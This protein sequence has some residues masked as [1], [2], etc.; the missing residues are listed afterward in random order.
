MAGSAKT[1]RLT[2]LSG[3][4]LLPHLAT[5]KTSGVIAKHNAELTL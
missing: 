5:P 4:F 1:G 3:G 2:V